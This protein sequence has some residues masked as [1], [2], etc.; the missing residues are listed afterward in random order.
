MKQLKTPWKI[1]LPIVVIFNAIAL[2]FGVW[3][4]PLCML[5]GAFPGICMA[6]KGRRQYGD[7]DWLLWDEK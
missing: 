3:L 7:W 6:I 4:G 2:Y 1:L 5:A